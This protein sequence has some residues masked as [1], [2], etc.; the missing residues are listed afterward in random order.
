MILRLVREEHLMKTGESYSFTL[1]LHG[2]KWEMRVT[3]EPEIYA[4]FRYGIRGHCKTTTIEG[5]YQ[6]IGRRFTTIDNAILFCL[7]H[8]NENAHIRNGFN[9]LSEALTLKKY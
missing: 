7:N 4:P 1:N 3:K 5:A 9:N 2:N 6:T 8:F